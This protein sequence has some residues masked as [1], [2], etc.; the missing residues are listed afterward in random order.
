MPPD[1]PPATPPGGGT[2]QADAPFWGFAKNLQG[3]KTGEAE[4]KQLDLRRELVVIAHRAMLCH[5]SHLCQMGG[6]LPTPPN[7]CISLQGQGR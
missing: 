3:E 4:M 1:V 6:A 2:G 7:W 5:T